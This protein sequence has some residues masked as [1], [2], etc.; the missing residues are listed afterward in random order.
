MARSL[1]VAL[2]LAVIA[3]PSCSNEPLPAI[4]QIVLHVDTDA[5]LALP[6]SR[7]LAPNEPNGLFDALRIEVVDADGAVACSTCRNEF[8]VDRDMLAREQMSVGVKPPVGRSDLGVRIRFYRSAR[9]RAEDLPADGILERIYALPP[10][11]AEGVVEVTA[12]LGF[13]HIGI[14][15]DPAAPREALRSGKVFSKSV[16]AGAVP[17]PCTGPAVAGRVCIPG[18]AY[19]MSAAEN[20]IALND[21]TA[22][23]R[24]AVISPFFLD[25]RERTVADLR[26]A[27]LASPTDPTRALATNH[28]TYSDAPGTKEALPINCITATLAD[29]VCAAAGGRL[30]TEAE[31]EFVGAGRRSAR[32]VW[33]EDE[34]QCGDAIFARLLQ[35]L[36]YADTAQ[37]RCAAL[38]VGPEPA[39]KGARD[40]LRISGGSI[41]DLAGNVSEWVADDYEPRG[42]ECWPAGVVFDPRCSSGA[43]RRSVRGASWDSEALSARA[44]I[45]RFAEATAKAEGIGFRCAFPDAR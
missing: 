34:P 45:R 6:P 31:R 21:E 1:I 17:R 3:A 5:P 30:P 29:R 12:F 32:F 15:P 43:S 37:G 16:Y 13:Q 11:V 27:G 14:A 44:A 38:G 35:V 20:S 28:C 24:V 4:G 7:S 42:S 22:T 18:G 33:G 2:L 10:I 19:W 26:A 40:V 39:G 25:E 41:F 23:E 8:T 36:G 9:S